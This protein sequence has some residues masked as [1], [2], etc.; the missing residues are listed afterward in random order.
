[1]GDEVEPR[2][3]FI[4]ENVLNTWI[5]C[6]HLTFLGAHGWGCF[7]E[8]YFEL[9]KYVANH[10]SID[11]PDY[12]ELLPSIDYDELPN[13]ENVKE[14][15]SYLS[16]GYDKKIFIA[17][18][19]VESL[20][21]SNFDFTN[22]INILSEEYPNFLFLTTTKID[23]NNKNVLFTENITNEKTDLLYLSYIS[24]ECDIIVG[25]TSGP[26]CYAQVKQNLMNP[27]KIFISFSNNHQEA[28]YFPHQ[29][30]KVIW[31]NQYDDENV[32]NTIK[33]NL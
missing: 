24:T 6:D 28:R 25:R 19:P 31:S 23:T 4:E 5:G 18:G 16:D 11:I 14:N 3:I 9:C 12:Y 7:F 13:I 22:I 21:S 15:F 20:Q 26:Y 30:S 32:I 2:R 17:T 27:N 29:E 33:Q 8:N 10:F 1:M